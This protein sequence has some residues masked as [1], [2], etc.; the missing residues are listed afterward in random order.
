MI[1]YLEKKA[2][3]LLIQLPF[4]SIFISFYRVANVVAPPSPF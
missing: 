4:W 1:N 3:R 2:V